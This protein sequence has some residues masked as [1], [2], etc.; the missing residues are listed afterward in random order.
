[1]ANAFPGTGEPLA[2]RCHHQRLLSALAEVAEAVVT[3][4]ARDVVGR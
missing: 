2:R 4:V 1:M 3:A